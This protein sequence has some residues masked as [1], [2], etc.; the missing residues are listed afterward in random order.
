MFAENFTGSSGN[1]NTDNQMGRLCA[2]T[3][4]A[5]R[6]S[7]IDDELRDQEADQAAEPLDL[8][9]VVEAVQAPA[10]QVNPQAF[11]SL[12]HKIH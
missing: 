4:R 3:Q 11:G 2:Q 8:E 6:E 7:D 1:V 12:F 5:E 10:P 9:N